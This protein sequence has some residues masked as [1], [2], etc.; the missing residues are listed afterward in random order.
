MSTRLPQLINGEFAESKTHTWIP[1][2]NPATQEVLCEAPAATAEEM[3]QAIAAAASARGEWAAASFEARAAVFL[4][5][6]ELLTTTWRAPVNR[7]P[8]RA[9]LEISPFVVV[10]GASR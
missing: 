7:P 1:V 5:A 6:A 2:T 10:V 4:R 9:T 8:R 3:E